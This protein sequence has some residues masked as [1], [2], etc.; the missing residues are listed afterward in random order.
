ML[1]ISQGYYVQQNVR[2]NT[3]I[4][5]VVQARD[6]N[7][8]RQC[9][10]LSVGLIYH[11]EAKRLLTMDDEIGFNYLE[12]TSTYLTMLFRAMKRL[13]IMDIQEYGSI[14]F[15]LPICLQPLFPI[16][17]AGQPYQTQC[18]LSTIVDPRPLGLVE[19][20]QLRG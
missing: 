2:K 16:Y 19:I 3:L 14:R 20:I 8:Q 17:L 13:L 6:N 1:C 4:I 9:T 12:L 7:R 11:H 5:E 10:T 18:Y 15:V